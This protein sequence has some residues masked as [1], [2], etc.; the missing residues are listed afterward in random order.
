MQVIETG[1]EGLVEIIPALYKDSRGWFYEFY[2]QNTFQKAGIPTNFPQE[3]TSFS[4]KGV[5]RGMH[6]QL[7]PFQQGKLVTVLSGRV[8]D[9]AVDLRKGSKT[10]GRVYHCEL[11]SE[12]RN[13]LM[14]PEGFA[15]GF[16]TLEDTI[17]YYKCTN[18]Y[19]KPLESGIV[20]NDPQLNIQWGIEN[21]IV[22]EKDNELPTLDE[23]LK[24]SII[25]RD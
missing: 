6:F 3:N 10:F 4:T 22:S 2:N 1:I 21:P 11:T 9:V 15:H 23:L 14:V 7:P 18:F 25:S 12:K 16:V 19:N 20:W 24:K 17:F 8:M 13:M 5:I